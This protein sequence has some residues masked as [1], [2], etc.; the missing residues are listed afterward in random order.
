MFFFLEIIGWWFALLSQHALPLPSRKLKT[1]VLSP[2][3]LGHCLWMGISPICCEVSY[4]KSRRWEKK[5]GR[6]DGGDLLMVWLVGS[7]PLVVNVAGSEP[8]LFFL[9][10]FFREETK[11][12]NTFPEN[13]QDFPLFSKLWELI[14]S[15]V[16]WMDSFSAWAMGCNSWKRPARIP[17]SRGIHKSSK[18]KV[19]FYQHQ[20]IL[21]WYCW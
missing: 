4:S 3:P 17:V 16:F 20:V 13:L 7:N 2:G 19:G 21:K 9:F 14:C 1:P 15:I 18:R 6:W 8:Y 10:W 12:K 11:I 5:S